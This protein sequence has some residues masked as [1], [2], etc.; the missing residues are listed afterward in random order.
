M[1][2]TGHPLL[3]RAYASANRFGSA[4]ASAIVCSPLLLLVPDPGG[5]EEMKQFHYLLLVG[6]PLGSCR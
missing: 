3:R 2:R 5:Q 4:L 1:Q 6:G